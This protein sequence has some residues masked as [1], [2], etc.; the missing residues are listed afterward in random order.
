MRSTRSPGTIEECPADSPHIFRAHPAFA[1]GQRR[2]LAGAFQR[3]AHRKDRG[4]QRQRLGGRGHRAGGQA[5]VDDH[6]CPGQTQQGFLGITQAGHGNG[7]VAAGH[8][9]LNGEFLPQPSH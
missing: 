7:P 5:L 4:R 9:Q 6:Q 2:F 1:I 3:L 8:L